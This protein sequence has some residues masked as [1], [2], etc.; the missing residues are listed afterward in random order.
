MTYLDANASEPL[1][2]EAREAV[3]AAL[4]VVGNPSS[5]HAAGRTA[6]HVLETAREQH[7]KPLGV[8]GERN[9]E[10]ILI[11]FGDVIV[12]VMQPEPRQFYQLEKLW[13]APKRARA[14]A[15]PAR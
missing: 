10:W 5:V 8:E 3:L 14:A 7:L 4:A 2:P 15:A 11:D 12:H 1:R 9:A 6:R 13:E